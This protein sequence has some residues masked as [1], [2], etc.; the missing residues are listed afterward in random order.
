MSDLE[1][2]PNV[3]KFYTSFV[4]NDALHILMEY[5]PKGD[6]YKVSYNFFQML[7]II[8]LIN[9]RFWKSNEWGRSIS[10][11]EI[12]GTTATSFAKLFSSSI[13]ITLFTE[14]S[15]AWTSSWVKTRFSS[16]EILEFQSINFKVSSS[17]VQ[18]LER[19]FTLLQSWWSHNHTI[20]KSMFGLL[21]ALCTT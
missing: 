19:P 17:K 2:H 18:G 1:E 7:I 12:S 3:I 15:N 16:W 5:A 10:A 8:N 14:T 6:L 21:A 9:F 11:K 20:T 4:E 13:T